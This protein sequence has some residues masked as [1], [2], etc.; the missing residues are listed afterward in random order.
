MSQGKEDLN[1]AKCPL[2]KGCQEPVIEDS[3]GFQQGLNK[4]DTTH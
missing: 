1:D 4:R 2:K 3:T